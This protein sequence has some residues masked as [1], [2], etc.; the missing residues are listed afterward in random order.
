MGERGP[1]KRE[2]PTRILTSRVPYFEVSARVG[3][4][5]CAAWCTAFVGCVAR[6]SP[7]KK[8]GKQHPRRNC[9]GD[10]ITQQAPKRNP[11]PQTAE[12]AQAGK[13]GLPQDRPCPPC[14]VP[15]GAT[16]K[17]AFP[18]PT[19]PCNRHGYSAQ[20]ARMLR[21]AAGSVRAFAYEAYFSSHLSRRIC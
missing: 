13:E 19:C 5:G 12:I 10:R 15:P 4:G 3:G 6:L 1:A 7:E 17:Y 2:S 21:T 11:E 9:E 16:R 20:H 14:L 8:I 18:A